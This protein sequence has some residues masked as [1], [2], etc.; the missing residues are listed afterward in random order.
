MAEKKQGMDAG[1]Y[2]LLYDLGVRCG[3]GLE[4]PMKNGKY[5]RESYLTA[6][7]ELEIMEMKKLSL[8]VWGKTEKGWICICMNHKMLAEKVDNH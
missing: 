2:R 1:R 8:S 5:Y 7:S 4:F 6:G 3:P